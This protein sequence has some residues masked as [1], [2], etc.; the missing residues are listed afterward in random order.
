MQLTQFTDYSLRVLLYLALKDDKATVREI[1]AN[2]RVSQNHLVKVVH[3]LSLLGY[4]H[5]TKGKN[6]GLRLA[7][8]P[9]KIRIGEAVV[10]FEPSLDLVECFNAKL[11]TCPIRGVCALEKALKYAK[12]A[13]LKNLNAHTIAD[14][15][16]TK[17]VERRKRILKIKACF[18]KLVV[19]K[20]NGYL[21]TTE[22]P[23]GDGNLISASCLET[24]L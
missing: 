19:E 8:S 16:Q 2:F 21:T 12:I 15:L 11:N 3:R 20:L 10:K 18:Y 17:T 13:F 22:P 4:I 14:F 1:A 23:F 5:S 9:E 7:I 6:G 24:Q